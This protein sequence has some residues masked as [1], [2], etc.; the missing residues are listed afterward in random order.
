[1][2]SMR[3]ALMNGP[4]HVHGGWAR[5][6]G[7]RFFEGDRFAAYRCG[8]STCGHEEWR[9]ESLGGS[10]PPPE[11][12]A[13][14]PRSRTEE[15]RREAAHEVI[16][17]AREAGRELGVMVSGGGGPEE[18]GSWLFSLVIRFPEDGPPADGK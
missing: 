3:E 9:P 13:M 17:R 1:M 10:N 2:T 14:P 11:P 18:D 4:N 15:E 8:A 7:V 12:G 5:T 16:R 6:G